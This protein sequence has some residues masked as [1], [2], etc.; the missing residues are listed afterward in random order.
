MKYDVIQYKKDTLNFFKDYD[1]NNGNKLDYLKRYLKMVKSEYTKKYL[2]DNTF[3]NTEER[4][5]KEIIKIKNLIKQEKQ[6]LKGE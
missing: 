6:K 3:D 4:I 1:F 2:T 5:Q